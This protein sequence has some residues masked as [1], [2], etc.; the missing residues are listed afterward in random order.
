MLPFYANTHTT[1]TATSAR[2]TA[3]RDQARGLIRNAVGAGD[4]DA[5]IFTG[6]GVTAAVHKLVAALC[7]RELAFAAA[8]DADH[9]AGHPAGHPVTTPAMGAAAAAAAAGSGATGTR[10]LPPVVVVGPW[11]HHSN[12]LPW[13]DAGAIIVRSP[14]GPD[15]NVDMV[16]LDR[17]L[18]AH[19]GAPVV[20]GAFAAA[21]NVTG[22]LADTDAITELLHTHGALAV[23]DYATGGPY[24][25]IIINPVS[26]LARKDAVLV[27]P[28]K[29]IGGVSSPGVLI[30]KKHMFRHRFPDQGGGGSVFF[31]TGE[32]HRYLQDLESREEGGTPDIVGSIRAGLAFQLKAAVGPANIV[33][34]ELRLAAVAYGRLSSRP[35][36]HV[37]GP[38]VAVADRL[39]VL[40][41]QVTVL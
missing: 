5:V 22:L 6:Q 41:F 35:D 21:S 16:G 40:S 30:A 14:E 17:I 9:P 28:H 12:I 33:A 18:Q 31:V 26:E 11:E 32:G 37:L 34:E 27:S 36:V 25:D 24:C 38:P 15:G 20:V 3:F 1:A 7:I 8:A 4:L 19:R 39:A 23:W 10:R 13:R 2:T 29:F